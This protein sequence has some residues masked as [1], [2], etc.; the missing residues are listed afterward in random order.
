MPKRDEMDSTDAHDVYEIEI[1]DGGSDP[2]EVM[3]R[4]V[5]AVEARERGEDPPHDES[6]VDELRPRGEEV[7]VEQL[8]D[9]LEELK[10]RSIRTLADYENFRRR[11]ER[12][13]TDHRRYAAADALAG[14][15][16]V[17]DNLERALRAEGSAEDLRAGVELIHRQMLDLVERFGATAVDALGERFNPSVHEA[18]ARVEDDSVAVPT[19]LEEYQRGYRLHDRLLRP[20]MVRVGLPLKSD[21]AES[22]PP[23]EPVE[24]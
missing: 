14:F 1:D 5:E 20:A 12:E 18:V 19:V 4:A 13:R 7:T 3:R 17:I 2:N 15:L 16:T 21:G 6:D 10:E 24:R 9:E 8:Q 22:A 11:V 23:E